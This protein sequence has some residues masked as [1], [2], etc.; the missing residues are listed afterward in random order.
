M[1]RE[2]LSFHNRP[3]LATNRASKIFYFLVILALSLGRNGL[4]PS[5]LEPLPVGEAAALEGPADTTEDFS[6]QSSSW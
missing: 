3:I 5:M 6:L 4:H 2:C 1:H